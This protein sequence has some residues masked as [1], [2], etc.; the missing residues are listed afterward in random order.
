MNDEDYYY[1]MMPFAFQFSLMDKWAKKFR[2]LGVRP[3]KWY[4]D[5]V[6]GRTVT[7]N[8]NRDYTTIEVAREINTFARTIESE[9]NAM[10][11]KHRLF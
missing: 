7:R 11:R 6:V 2:W 1:D 8:V 9:Y 5:E 4:V 3:A 10:E